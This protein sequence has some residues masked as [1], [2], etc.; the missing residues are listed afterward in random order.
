MNQ[1]GNSS[2]WL[3][4]LDPSREQLHP[5]LA[6]GKD[7]VVDAGAGSGKTRTLTARF[8]SLL[9]EGYDLRSISAITFTKKAAREMR[10]RIREV[11]NHIIV[12]SE[13]DQVSKT[14]WQ[15]LYGELD[16]ARIGTIHSLAAE[17]IRNHPA[18]LGVDPR[19]KMLDETDAI[20]LQAEAVQAGL[21]W[22]VDS[23]A[24]SHLLTDIGDWTL[25]QY[26]SSMLKRRL[27]IGPYLNLTPSETWER[28]QSSI[29]A[30][31]V[32]FANDSVVSE[33]F[34]QLNHLAQSDSMKFA[35][36][37]N[38]A[39]VPYLQILVEQWGLFQA[40]NNAGEWMSAAGALNQIFR[41]LKQLG[42]KANW[43]DQDPKEI[44]SEIKL[45]VEVHMEDLVDVDLNYQL[46]R[47]VAMEILPALKE[48]F[49]VVQQQ[50]QKQK[51]ERQMLDFD[52]LEFLALE[53][54]EKNQVVRTFWQNR[55]D[56][57]LVD[58]FQD[59]NDRQR[60]IIKILGGSENQL[61]IVGDGKQ[62]I[63]RF[64]GADVAVFREERKNISHDGD[65]FQ[66]SRTY[67][68]HAGLTQD[69]NVLLAEVLGEIDDVTYVEPFS[70][71][72]PERAMPNYG[73]DVPFIEFHLTVG[74]KSDGAMLTAAHAAGQRVIELIEA[75]RNA[76]DELAY[77]DVAVLC[78]ASGSFKYY[79]DAFEELN[80]PYTTVAGRGFYNRPEI[81]DVLNSLTALANPE[82]DLAV[83]GFLRSPAVGFSDVE[84]FKLRKI[85]KE[86]AI[87]GLLATLRET[88]VTDT[89]F[90]TNKV[91]Q[92]LRVYDE[93]HSLIGR[94]SPAEVL[95]RYLDQ[96]GYLALLKLAGQ[97]RAAENVKK[98]LESIQK[99][100][101]M[102]L[103]TYLNHVED[104]K[105]SSAREGEAQELS[106]GSVQIMSVHQAKGLEFPVVIIG[107]ASKTGRSALG[108][109]VQEPFGVVMPYNEQ[110]ITL[111]S[112]GQI[113]R[114]KYSSGIY[115]LAAAEEKRRD[116]A[117]SKRLLYVAA[118]RAKDKLIVNGVVAGIKKDQTVY[119]PRG[120]LG[121]LGC[122]LGLDVVKLDYNPEG[123][124][125][126]SVDL[127][128]GDLKS[129]AVFY[130]LGVRFSG[131]Q[132][133]RLEPDFSRQSFDIELLKP[134]PFDMS[135]QEHPFL[136]RV[137]Q[138][139]TEQAPAWVIG[140][141]VHRSLELWRFPEQVKTGTFSAWASRWLNSR[142]IYDA[143]QVQKAVSQAKRLLGKFLD[144]SLYKAMSQAERR[145]AELPFSWMDEKGKVHQGLIDALFLH[146]GQWYLI[147]FKTDYLSR[148]ED[149]EEKISENGYLEQI[150]RYQ[151]AVRQTLRI[152]S[153]VLLCF[154]NV[155]NEIVFYPR[156]KWNK[157]G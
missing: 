56:A 125:I 152:D 132:E 8:V 51:E 1:N 49:N 48:V 139:Q 59:T 101:L 30:P 103:D 27:E 36:K 157:S 104:I 142:G 70:P 138:V 64:R 126:H 50:Y 88:L 122:P 74:K 112:D 45:R 98:L 19:F 37:K 44:V 22:A 41:N 29:I 71:L 81:R 66:L 40:A 117:E 90:C 75:S 53:L 54:L 96:T 97:Q 55:I 73:I 133:T 4:I 35:Q 102:N 17:I 156:N 67:R 38:D 82:D 123:D 39:F 128:L 119:L 94:F 14:R 111:N 2:Y 106:S 130:E 121:E 13:I 146:Q 18:E 91:Q 21:S 143:K 141:L 24:A 92:A 147:E 149:L 95:K 153:E 80:I 7:I 6:R 28:W 78:R 57:I 129:R 23:T 12:D 15:Q 10:N 145:F 137:M 62:S 93:I 155:G 69:F 135:D 113:Q 58:E 68:S 150:E 42:R 154:L 148:L 124:V 9:S 72:V 47:R 110:K 89:G 134:I 61:F 144:H 76:G 140:E 33:S 79:E 16:A 83:V 99:S 26:L 127:G 84:L 109:F 3:D 105:N 108:L 31:I 77:G 131:N 52:D 120:W 151:Q 25:K 32:N 115:H 85:Q 11:I 46:D 136:D 107:D 116:M 65:Y 60:R 114:D 100:G 86:R 5:I 34:E 20:L 118:T 87:C 43:N 63:Y